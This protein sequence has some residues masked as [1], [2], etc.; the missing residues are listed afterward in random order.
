MGLSM[1]PLAVG[2]VET[3]TWRE[4]AVHRLAQL[5]GVHVSTRPCWCDVKYAAHAAVTAPNFVN[6]PPAQFANNVIGSK[7]VNQGEGM[8]NSAKFNAFVQ[9]VNNDMMRPRPVDGGTPGPEAA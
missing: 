6:L 2:A 1:D 8:I 5:L 4:R 3:T 7:F 9:D